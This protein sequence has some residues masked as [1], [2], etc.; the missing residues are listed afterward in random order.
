MTKVGEV[1][2]YFDKIGVAVIKTI[3]DLK[4]GA[5]IKFSGSVEF[6][7]TISSMQ[8]DHKSIDMAK[9]GDEAGL[10]VDE[11]VKPGDEVFLL[12]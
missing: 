6:S 9:S 10:K 12:E 2:H 7:Q 5:K 1:T 4:V 3:V 8:V 11:P